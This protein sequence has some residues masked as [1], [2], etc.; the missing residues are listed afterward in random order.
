LRL[1]K[2]NRHYKA[3]RASPDWGT[4]RSRKYGFFWDSYAPGVA[5]MLLR[6]A[7][8]EAAA[9]GAGEHWQGFLDAWTS[10]KGNEHVVTSPKG[11]AWYIKVRFIFFGQFFWVVYV[12]ECG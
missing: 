7:P 8:A 10:L 9:A 2:T 12:F 3:L 5:W 6:E 11:Y 1:S 4:W